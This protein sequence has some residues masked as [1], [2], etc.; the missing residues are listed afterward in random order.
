MG[1]VNFIKRVFYGIQFGMKGAN[2]VIISQNSSNQTDNVG[3]VQSIQEN[4]LSKDLLKGE[5]TQ[6][7]E[8]LRYKDYKVYNESKKYKYLG[9]GNAT[10]IDYDDKDL[11]NFSFIVEN[12]VICES[13]FDEFNRIDDYGYDRYVLSFVYIIN[14]II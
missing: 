14:I 13:I 5:V 6:Q 12:K 2:N 3:V 11:N 10:K 1:L 8:E 9:D 4:R 7:V